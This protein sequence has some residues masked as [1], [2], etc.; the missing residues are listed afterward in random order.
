MSDQYT[1]IIE[2]VE[3]RNILLEEN[4]KLKLIIKEMTD[5]IE[6]L[7]RVITNNTIVKE[8]F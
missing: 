5:R 6:F 8:D 7:T 4:E 3:Q 2:L 1:K